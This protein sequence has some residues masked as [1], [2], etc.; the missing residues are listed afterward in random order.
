M[1]TPSLA[2][3]KTSADGP[4]MYAWPPTPPHEFEVMS[5]TSGVGNG[6]PKP[7]LI[8]WAAKMSAECAVDD[9]EIISAMLEKGMEKAAIDHIKNA[10]NRS[11]GEKADRG[12]I[13]H[14]ALEA[15]IA[16]KPVS[17]AALAIQLTDAR[18]P[19]TMWKSTKGMIEGALLF[20]KES[21]LKVTHS[22]A[23]VFS[24][25]HEYAG[26]AD[27]FGTMKIGTNVVPVVVDF[28]TGKAVYDDTS[29]QLTAYA[30]AD[31]IGLDDGTELPMPKGIKL[32][33]VVRPMASGTYEKV[34]FAL[35]DDVFDLF[36]HCLAIAQG[37]KILAQSRRP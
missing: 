21:K 30:R 7:F 32:G 23:T 26:T 12:T 34:V 13:V 28:K 8:P 14:A 20:L 5:V 9:H 22:E 19:R 25:E 3:K 2:K 27:L 24:R 11:A 33:I 1:T 6:Y 31:F 16:K 15:F 37:R 35:G 29:M 17:D 10:R 4:R 18:V 36:L